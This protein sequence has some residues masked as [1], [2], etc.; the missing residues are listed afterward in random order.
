M[1]LIHFL[2]KQSNK[3]IWITCLILSV[4]LSQLITG[5]MGKLLHGKIT[6]DYLLTGFV[7]SF[8]VTGI[9]VAL[10]IFLLSQLRQ[11][12]ERFQKMSQSLIKSEERTRL[13]ISA[14]KSALW[15]LDLTTWNIFLS[16]G[17]LP[18]LCQ[19]ENTTFTTLKILNRLVP[20]EERPMLDKAIIAAMKGENDST[21]KVTHRVRKLDGSFIWV[22]SEGKITERDT[23]GR[24]LRIS[25]I[26]RDITELKIAEDQI[27]AQI[28]QILHTNTE[29]QVAN[30]KL[31]QAKS[32]LIQSEKLAAIGL[33]AAGVAHE[34]N[35]PIAYINSNLGTLTKYLNNIFTMM[36]KYESAEKW[37]TDHPLELEELQSF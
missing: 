6:F 3:R 1:P 15:D 16:D 28:K 9:V 25:G 30:T 27:N 34:I 35:N 32:Q 14:S 37:I 18:F 23:N 36:N 26:N 17:W 29:L 8:L 21:Y 33:L 11:D 13:A 5:M 20:E 4:A 19:N 31:E 12:A 10:L 22:R 24:A 2:Q 7:V